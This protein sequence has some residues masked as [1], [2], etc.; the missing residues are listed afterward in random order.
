LSTAEAITSSI[1]PEKGANLME[2]DRAPPHPYHTGTFPLLATIN[3]KEIR[4]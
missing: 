1:Y 4:K 3:I 2:R